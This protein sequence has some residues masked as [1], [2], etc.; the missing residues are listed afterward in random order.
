MDGHTVSKKTSQQPL[1]CTAIISRPGTSDPVVYSVGHTERSSIVSD[2]RT[3]QSLHRSW[4]DS[5]NE[6]KSLLDSFIT[7]ESSRVKFNDKAEISDLL[8][9]QYT[10]SEDYLAINSPLSDAAVV[11]DSVFLTQQI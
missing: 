5:A 6:F 9:V 7:S 8:P 10:M 3:M 1:D 11:Q 4:A 2:Y